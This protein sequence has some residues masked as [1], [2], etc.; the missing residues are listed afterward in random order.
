MT[1]GELIA[2]LK[3]LGPSVQDEQVLLSVADGGVA[4]ITVAVSG[5][6]YDNRRP[7]YIIGVRK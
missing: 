7:V 5:G 6:G 3:N 4:A 1:V 2:A